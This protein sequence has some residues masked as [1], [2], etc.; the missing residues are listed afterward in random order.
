MAKYRAVDIVNISVST[1][2][3]H[4]IAAVRA[5][6]HMFHEKPMALSMVEAEEMYKAAERAK[7]T[8]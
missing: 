4:E 7:V 2:L 8:H 1:Y 3:R 5:G 6:K